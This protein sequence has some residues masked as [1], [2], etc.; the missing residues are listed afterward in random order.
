MT[1]GYSPRLVPLAFGLGLLAALSGCGGGGKTDVSGT[2][3][4]R[5]Q[6]PKI[7]GLQISFMDSEGA[8]VSAPIAEDGA[9]KAS[10]VSAGEVKVCFIYVPPEVAGQEQPKSGP[11]L[12]KPGQKGGPPPKPA[13]G[14][15]AIKNP[16]PEPLRDF[17]TSQ[18][19]FTVEAGKPNVFD[20][21]LP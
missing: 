12:M 16:I 8:Q 11:R 9:Y 19:A 7:E 15:P 5:G 1:T 2:I 6:S 3:K 13:A 10:G 21:D 14:K 17:G 4:L 18:L 20:Y